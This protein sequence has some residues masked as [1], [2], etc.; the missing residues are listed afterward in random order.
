MVEIVTATHCNPSAFGYPAAMFGRDRRDHKDLLA[1]LQPAPRVSAGTREL[2]CSHCGAKYL[3]GP[4]EPNYWRGCG[5]CREKP[6]QGQR[7]HLAR[8]MPLFD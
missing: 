8:E 1:D 3:A 2:L 6:A 4:I 7:V 5:E